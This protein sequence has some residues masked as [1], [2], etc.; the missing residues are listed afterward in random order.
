MNRQRD[1]AHHM[2]FEALR[3]SIAAQF[4]P[5]DARHID[6]AYHVAAQLHEGQLRRSGDPVI[7]H[8]LAVA[9]IVAGAEGSAQAVSAALLHDVVD[10]TPYSLPRL[11]REFGARVAEIVEGLLRRDAFHAPSAD[12]DVVLLALADR[13]HNL[14]T[15]RFLAR[16]RQQRVARETLEHFVPLAK[17]NSLPRLG[18]QLADHA[19]S[20]LGWAE[21]RRRADSTGL[22]LLAAGAMLLPAEMRFRWFEEWLG[23]LSALTGRGA[24]VRFAAQTLR[25]VPALAVTLHRSRR[26][27]PRRGAAAGS[28]GAGSVLLSVLSAR[29][30]MPAWL[31]VSV[32]VAGTAVTTAVLF[33]PT[34][35]AAQRLISIIRAWRKP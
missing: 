25:G 33:A 19:A 16:T 5:E 26:P 4:E 20:L 34:D 31:V 28:S 21:L 13:L 1:I 9:G 7:T 30:E 11:R 35:V 29:A 6:R 12:R 2:S 15:A 23:E 3:D 22:R 8:S 10:D 24:R 32:S 18:D 17:R 14:R 27:R